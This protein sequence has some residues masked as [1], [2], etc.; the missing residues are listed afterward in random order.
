MFRGRE[1]PSERMF[2]ESL[3]G[4]ELVSKED[5]KKHRYTAEEVRKHNTFADC[6]ITYQ[7]FVYNCTPYINFHPGGVGCF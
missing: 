7:G 4:V 1:H 2:R 3:K 6:W 5:V